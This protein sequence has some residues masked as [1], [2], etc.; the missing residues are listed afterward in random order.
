MKAMKSSESGSLA[1]RLDSLRNLMISLLLLGTAGTV[2]AL[3]TFAQFNAVTTNG[4]NTFSTGLI[5][6]TNVPNGGTVCT[7]DSN[8]T[9]P[10]TCNALISLSNMIAGDS[11]VGTLTVTNTTNSNGPVQLALSISSSSSNSIAAN[12]PSGS[13]AGL[14]LLLFRCI[15]AGNFDQPSPCNT[16]AG[17]LY[18][19]YGTCTGTPTM[20]SSGFGSSQVASADTAD[21]NIVVGGVACT[22][23][24]SATALNSVSSVSIT[25]FDAI[26]Q[27]GS[28][29]TPALGIAQGHSDDYAAVMYLPGQAGNNQSS[30]GTNT[31]TLT[32]AWTATGVGSAH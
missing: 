14:G 9:S 2:I 27:P 31:T 28:T 22:P 21:A 8:G 4:G 19:L 29:G 7:A 24:N 16:N 23:G 17:Q 20:G 13:S 1:P 5:E 12:A 10:A 6:F 30:A 11:A 15:G 25:G 26:P 3:S 18:P 32:F